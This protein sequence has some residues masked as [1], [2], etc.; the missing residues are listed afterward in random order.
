VRDSAISLRYARPPLSRLALLRPGAIRH[1]V[2][3]LIRRFSIVV[4]RPETPVR[5]LSGGNVQRL[6]VGR[7]LDGDPRLVVAAYPT[8]GVDVR[9]AAFVHDLLLALRAAGGAVLLVSEELDELLVLS[10]RLLVLYDGRIAGELSRSEF[11]DRARIGRL[12]T[13]G[14]T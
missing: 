9:G 14:E 2:R 8:R 4:P 12:M 10:D 3:G 7:E 1:F 5:S 13:G 11:D 6:V